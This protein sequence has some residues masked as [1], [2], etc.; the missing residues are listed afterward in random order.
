MSLIHVIVI[1]FAFKI[2]NR[3]QVGEWALDLCYAMSE[4]QTTMENRMKMLDEKCTCRGLSLYNFR[5]S[6]EPQAQEV[7]RKFHHHQNQIAQNQW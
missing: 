6:K 7:G 3:C 2:Q 1:G 4:V 5:T